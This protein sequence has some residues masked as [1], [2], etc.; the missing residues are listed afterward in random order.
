VYAAAL[1][2]Y[3]TA[4]HVESVLDPLAGLDSGA[5]GVVPGFTGRLLDT[6]APGA[7][8]RAAAQVYRDMVSALPEGVAA[9]D[10]AESAEDKPALAVTEATVDAWGG[11]VTAAVRHCE[12]LRIGHVV[13]A[14]RPA[15]I[16]T[17]AAKV[18]EYPDAAT[19]F[20]ALRTDQLNAVWTSTADPDIPA[21]AVVLADRTAL[22]RA[23]NV[24]PL[25]RRNELSEMQVLALNEVAGVLDTAALVQMRRQVAAGDHPGQAA[26]AFLAE[27]PL[28]ATSR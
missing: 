24:V 3:G 1:R 11:D 16:G 12:Q 15:V 7:T 27:H 8:A 4:A 5:I 25:Y 14:P 6:F 26:D 22:I 9:G 18:R 20:E 19:L 13:G 17:C 23:E 10:Y 28:G 2:T 21:D